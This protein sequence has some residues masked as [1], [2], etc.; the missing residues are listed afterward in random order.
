MKRL[1]KWLA[2]MMGGRRRTGRYVMDVQ[3]DINRD[4]LVAFLSRNTPII[5]AAEYNKLDAATKALFVKVGG[6]QK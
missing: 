1:K 6:K 2:R 3:R 4:V 5:T